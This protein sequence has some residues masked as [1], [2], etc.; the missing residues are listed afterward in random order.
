MDSTVIVLVVLG[1]NNLALA[2]KFDHLILAEKCPGFQ[3]NVLIPEDYVKHLP[4]SQYTGNV[5]R[6]RFGFDIK[7]IMEVKEERYTF[8]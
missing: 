7:Q 8:T 4:D 1:L 5:T 2:A 3:H 6:L